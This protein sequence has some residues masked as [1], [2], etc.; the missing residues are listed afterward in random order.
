MNH[1]A[2]IACMFVVP[3]LASFIVVYAHF[4]T[5]PITNIRLKPDGTFIQITRDGGD[6]GS[7]EDAIPVAEAK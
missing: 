4:R 7:W 2:F 6:E 5:R 3:I 1:F